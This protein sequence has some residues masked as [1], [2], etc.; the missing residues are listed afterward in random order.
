MLFLFIYLF[1]SFYY[2]LYF[3]LYYIKYNVNDLKENKKTRNI[4]IKLYMS[5]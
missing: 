3:I 1:I 5:Y 2:I 4:F